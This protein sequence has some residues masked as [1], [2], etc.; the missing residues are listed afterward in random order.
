MAGIYIH[1]PFCKSRC[2]YCD[3]YSSTLKNKEA[4]YVEALSKELIQR[5]GYLHGETVETVYLGGGTPSQLS[6]TELQHIIDVIKD[7]Y[8]WQSVKE[9]TL[10]ANPDDLSPEYLSSLKKLGFNRLSIGVQTFQDKILKL[11]KRRHNAKQVQQAVKDAHSA[12]FTNISIDLIYG[13]PEQ[14][15]TS[16]QEDVELA[17][18]TGA[19][20]ISAYGLTYEEGTPIFRMRQDKVIQE[21]TDEEYL[22]RYTYLVKRLKEAGF[23][24]YEISNFAQP[25]LYSQH[26]SSYWKGIKYLG[27]GPSAHSYNGESRQWNVASIEEYITAIN[28]NAS[29]FERE[30][31]NLMSQYNDFVMTSLRTMWGINLQQLTD[32]YGTEYYRYLLDKAAIYLKN[33]KLAQEGNIIKL[34]EQGVFVSDGIISDLF[35]V[36]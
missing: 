32:K 10:E 5:K 31:L 21:A 26:N 12:G 13:L 36:N 28:T 8:G 15:M 18:Q 35:Q 17:I 11:I 9:A 1:I 7:T 24:H 2:I 3:F 23:I 30:E 4:D 22:A 25:E 34:S 16:W 19:T 6:I 20:H 14:D 29:C 33:G 27:C